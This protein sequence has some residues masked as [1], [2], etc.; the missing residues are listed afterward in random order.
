MRITTMEQMGQK[1]LTLP[2]LKDLETDLESVKWYLWHGNVFCA[3][4]RIQW[5]AM[6]LDVVE[7]V[8]VPDRE[9]CNRLCQAVREFERYLITNE[10]FTRFA[11]VSST[12]GMMSK[13]VETLPNKLLHFDITRREENVWLVSLILAQA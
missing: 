6:D 5:V 8:D 10:P 4:Q 13:A 12:P 1:F 11:L 7:A 3:V 2:V 9:Q